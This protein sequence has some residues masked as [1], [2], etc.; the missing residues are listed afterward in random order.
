MDMH[1]VSIS[2]AKATLTSLVRRAEDEPVYL[3]RHSK[4]AGVLLS[5]TRYEELL[6]RLEDAEDA[7]AVLTADRSDLVDLDDLDRKLDGAEA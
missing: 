6:D 5:A 7:L 4:P 2:E 1:M 3:L